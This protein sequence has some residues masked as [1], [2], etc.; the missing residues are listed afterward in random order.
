MRQLVFLVLLAVGGTALADDLAKANSALASR[1]YPEALALYGKLASSGNAEAQLRLGEMYWYGEGV[2]L[3]RAKGDALF[4]RAAA[5]GNQEAIAAQSLSANRAQRSAAI[6]HWTAGYDGADVTAGKFACVA[7]TIPE[8]SITNAE[9]KAATAAIAA[10]YAC[11]DAF[12]VKLNASLPAG[13]AI[14]PDVA[15]VMSEQET[16]QAISH[17]DKVYAGVSRKAEENA[18]AIL[19]RRDKWQLATVAYVNDKNKTNEA[20]LKQHALEREIAQR[21]HANAANDNKSRPAR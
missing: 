18:A 9:V 14:P 21:A 1:A 16:Q 2:A 12:V 5:A 8:V 15:I 13:K 20:R 6:A 7:P 3:D 17:L 19:A 11:H 10:W 4:V